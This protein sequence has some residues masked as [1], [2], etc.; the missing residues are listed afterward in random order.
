L[1]QWVI[2]QPGPKRIIENQKSI[3]RLGNPRSDRLFDPPRSKPRVRGGNVTMTSSSVRNHNKGPIGP[4][5]RKIGGGKMTDGLDGLDDL[6][7]SI[8]DKGKLGLVPKNLRG[9]NARSRSL[10]KTIGGGRSA[11]HWP[12]RRL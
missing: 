11:D 6:V 8:I 9:M 3:G 12:W 7:D 10:I 1:D 2:W 4:L 5:D